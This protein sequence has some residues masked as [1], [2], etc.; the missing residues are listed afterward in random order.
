MRHK[1]KYFFLLTAT[2]LGILRL[3]STVKIILHKKVLENYAQLKNLTNYL[4]N[5]NGNEVKNP[6]ASMFFAVNITILW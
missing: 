3:C 6:F 2:A 4:I 1:A 5:K